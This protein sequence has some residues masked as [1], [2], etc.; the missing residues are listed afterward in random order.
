MKIRVECHAG[1]R[2]DEEPRAVWLGERRF[3]VVELLDRWLH[4]QH[5]YF[6]VRVDNWRPFLLPP[7]PPP[8]ATPRGG[9][10]RSRAGGGPGPAPRGRGRRATDDALAA[11]VAASKRVA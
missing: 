4:P 8:P 1:Y 5:R 11:V 9:G 3:E 2:G 6:K 7:A 10:G